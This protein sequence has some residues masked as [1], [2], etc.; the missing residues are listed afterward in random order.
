MELFKYGQTE[1]EY[2]KRRDRKLGEAIDRIGTI[3]REVTPTE[4]S[5]SKIT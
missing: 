5:F 1:I 2:L 4:D 3:G